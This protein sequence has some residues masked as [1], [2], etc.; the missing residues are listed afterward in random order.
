MTPKERKLKRRVD[1]LEK[2]VQELE[3]R[4]QIT[5]I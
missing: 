2:K 5:F 3:Q 4:P 1:E